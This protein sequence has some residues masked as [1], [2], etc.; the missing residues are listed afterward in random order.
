MAK[1]TSLFLAMLWCAAFWALI[2]CQWR[3]V[4]LLVLLI[5][6]VSVAADYA[7]GR[8]RRHG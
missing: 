3:W 7:A 1:L 4:F 6:L 5:G 2:A 8:A